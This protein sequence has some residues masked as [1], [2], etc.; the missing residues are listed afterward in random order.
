MEKKIKIK[1]AS[2]TP[3]NETLQKL[4]LNDT[5]IDFTPV[6]VEADGKFTSIMKAK[7]EFNPNN[8]SSTFET[9]E[10]SEE[11]K[12]TK[13]QLLNQAKDALKQ[14]LT[15]SKELNDILKK[16]QD[17]SKEDSYN[18]WELN[19]EKNTA[20]LKSK[21]ATIFKQN[22]NLCLAHNGK[23][24]LFKSVPELH[25]WLKD[26]GYPLPGNNII[27]HE[28][29]EVKETEER[30]WLDLLN[31]YNNNKKKD[32]L[33]SGIDQLK[34]N[35][36]DNDT[37]ENYQTYL[38][39]YIKKYV[40]PVREISD[41]NAEKKI[42]NKQIDYADGV[43]N[44]IVSQLAI[45]GKISPE[46][47]EKTLKRRD[48][49]ED[50][51][52]DGLARLKGI[53]K[54]IKELSTNLKEPS[55]G[56]TYH[57]HN[58]Q[59]LISKDR[60]ARHREAPNPDKLTQ[61]LGKIIDKQILQA[62]KNSKPVVKPNRS[63]LKKEAEVEE[64]SGACVSTAALGP[65]VAYATYPKKK[66]EVAEEELQEAAMASII[67][68]EHKMYGDTRQAVNAFLTWY[69]RNASSIKDGNIKLPDDFIN[70][71]D[72]IIVPKFT[73]NSSDSMSKTWLKII[74][75][76]LKPLADK[77][78]RSK[79]ISEDIVLENLIT[80]PNDK[81]CEALEMELNSF[82]PDDE[83]YAF[84]KVKLIPGESLLL[85]AKGSP[86]FD[87]RLKWQKA[88]F[89]AKLD[90]NAPAEATVKAFSDLKNFVDNNL[91]NNYNFTAE[92]L[93]LIKKYNLKPQA[94]SIFESAKKYP[95]LNKLMGQRLVEDD[96]PAD[97]ATGSPISSDMNNTNTTSTQ[98]TTDNTI[99][100]DIPDIDLGGDA[101][102]EVGSFGDINIDAGGYSPD[103]V[104]DAEMPIPDM[105]EYK[106]IDVLLNDDNNDV[107][108]KI[109]N[110]DTKE[111][112]IKDLE[113][114]DV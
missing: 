100:S 69:K 11:Q 7:E 72:N 51:I 82:I 60:E 95:W 22:N 113:D 45:P 21:N 114:I 5:I 90:G 109:Q 29:V 107:K 108:V 17:L 112:E 19:K 4:K 38:N 58:I 80:K 36:L 44:N 78:S 56:E 64:C 79:N 30:N 75:N 48:N 47:Y 111:T 27:I 28:S 106:I 15:N 14:T 91:R 101:G 73:N 86:N 6:I 94:E 61:G 74:M 98:T 83:K 81:I 13:E 2:L 16:I 93:D 1:S 105:P 20:T 9:E 42:L 34:K 46:D 70:T 84:G 85:T 8:I 103:E 96:T 68:N 39:D 63:L 88:G 26:K 23:I 102:N 18:V 33:T 49:I 59:D 71:F 32:D 65:A 66:E 76:R 67:P 89:Q 31:D 53:D 57:F 24:E 55:K 54:K 110:Q 62:D 99:S 40:S 50:I 12:E 43:L 52:S 35:S 97:F 10:Q 92:Q 77:I 3:L 41:L 37:L 104:E 25:E 87:Q